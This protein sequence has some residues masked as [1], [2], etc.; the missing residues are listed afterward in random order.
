M[1]F[2][3]FSCKRYD[4][5]QNQQLQQKSICVPVYQST[6]HRHPNSLFI[7]VGSPLESLLK[8]PIEYTEYSNKKRENEYNTLS[9]LVMKSYI[10]TNTLSTVR[11]SRI[12]LKM[13]LKQKIPPRITIR[14]HSYPLV[15]TRT[16]LIPL[17]PTYPF[18]LVNSFGRA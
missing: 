11:T 18:D 5:K 4:Q 9:N 15:P 8:T 6:S 13:S 1:V 17:E 16:H 3:Y 12:G 2:L 10:L 7:K 14:P